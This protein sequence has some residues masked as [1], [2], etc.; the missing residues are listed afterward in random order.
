MEQPSNTEYN[1]NEF[2]E[3]TTPEVKQPE[4]P[5]RTTPTYENKY[6]DKKPGRN[7]IGVE[8]ATINLWDKDAFTPEPLDTDAIKDGSK[9][10]TFAL[11]SKEFKMNPVSKAKIVE[12]LK[13]LKSKDYTI[14]FV[15]D[16]ANDLINE[17]NEIFGKDKVQQFIPFAS[18]KC[19]V[20]N[21]TPVRVPTDKNIK[22]AAHSFIRPKPISEYKFTP[23]KEFHEYAAFGQIQRATSISTI[24]GQNNDEV[25][26]YI[27]I[28]DP[29]LGEVKDI[30]YTKSQDS[31]SL[32]HMAR[33]IGMTS[34]NLT[35]GGDMDDIQQLLF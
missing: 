19:G 28:V 2:S 23:P 35:K 9:F 8:L 31:A 29:Y 32:F 18:F 13:L 7:L 6:K 14:R 4:T 12:V 34:Y 22:L 30:D 3:I 1:N 25:S 15:V 20:D 5:V 24:Y 33:K 10:F 21:L 11:A 27:I 16:Q 17:I 26:D